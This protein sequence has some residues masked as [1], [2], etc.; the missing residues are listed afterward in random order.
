MNLTPI[1]N[2][3]LETVPS[4]YREYLQ[5]KFYPSVKSIV[6][7]Y[8][9]SVEVNNLVHGAFLDLGMNIGD[10]KE[11]AIYLTETLTKELRRPKYSILTLQEIG[12]FISKGIRRE[13]PTFNGQM[14]SLNIQN[15]YYW[16]DR[17]LESNERR[18]ALKKF[19]E[20]LTAQEHVPKLDSLLFSNK[21]IMSAFQ[22]YKSVGEMPVSGHAYYSIIND[23]I[24]Q[25]YKGIKTLVTDPIQRKSIYEACKVEYTET[26]QKIKV[27]EERKGNSSVAN[28]IASLLMGDLNSDSPFQNMVKKAYLKAFWDNLIANG[29]DLKL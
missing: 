22:R 7:D 2:K 23:Q 6:S 26:L 27:K 29:E 14:N 15:I 5:A 9:L 1:E 24:G 11:T 25:D 18:E 16:I 12:L 28:G 3:A 21:R 17:G 19:N 20:A 8:N 13:Y 10:H 4:N